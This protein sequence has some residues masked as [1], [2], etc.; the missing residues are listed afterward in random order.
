MEQYIVSRKQAKK[1]GIN[2]DTVDY[3]RQIRRIAQLDRVV[4][5]TSIHRDNKF[6]T[7][8]FPYIRYCGFEPIDFI[9]N[10]LANLQP[11]MLERRKS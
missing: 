7:H 1:S 8:L 6:N 11:Y 4:L 3:C 10:Y 5:D 2:L 9:K